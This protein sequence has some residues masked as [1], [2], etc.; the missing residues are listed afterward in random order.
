MKNKEILIILVIFFVLYLIAGNIRYDFPDFQ[1][2]SKAAERIAGGSLLY[3]DHISYFGT[4]HYPPVFLYTLGGFYYLFGVYPFIAKGLLAFFNILAA[5]LLYMI[6]NRFYGKKYAVLSSVLFLVNPFTFSAVYVGYIDNFVIFF[7][8]LS[9]YFL[10]KDMPLSGGIALATGFM[11]K[12]FPVLLFAVLIPYYLGQHRFRFL[13]RY[14]AAFMVTVIII[15][16]PFLIL[17]PGEFLKY[18]FFY[19]FERTSASLS[20]YYYYLP[21]LG[22]SF[23]PVAAQVIFIG[24]LSYWIYSSQKESISILMRYIPLL[25]LG[26]FILNRINY[27]HYL[28]YII[29][30]ISLILVEEY[31][32][33]SRFL[34]FQVWKHLLLSFFI[35]SAGCVLWSYP[36]SMG[37]HDFKSSIYFWAGSI[38][39]YIGSLYLLII[40]YLGSARQKTLVLHGRKIPIRRK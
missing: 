28:L 19:N 33:K 12:P 37:L 16:V 31:R 4:Y 30:F 24:R 35:V 25:F 13:I 14:I 5:L 6:A 39:Y 40:F 8:L 11:S 17:T 27:P 2:H 9:I 7:M 26:F 21:M 22:T 1:D 29:P 23:L 18:A 15:S 36:W 20:L 32:C 3:R 38:I 34:N 10:L